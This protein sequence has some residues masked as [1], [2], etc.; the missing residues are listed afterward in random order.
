MN[1]KAGLTL[2]ERLSI[3]ATCVG[4]DVDYLSFL[5]LFIT[6]LVFHFISLIKNASWLSR[7]VFIEK[8]RIDLQI[9]YSRY[10]IFDQ[11][12]IKHLNLT[13]DNLKS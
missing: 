5:K 10:Y 12:M 4:Q 7:S 13:L 8:D 2:F 1:Q 6:S 9:I 3:D 11:G